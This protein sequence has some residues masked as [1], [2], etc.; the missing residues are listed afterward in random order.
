MFPVDN[1]AVIVQIYSYIVSSISN[2][3]L[4]CEIQGRKVSEFNM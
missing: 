1:F 2:E 4:V 3:S